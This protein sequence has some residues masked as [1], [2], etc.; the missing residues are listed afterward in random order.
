MT[1]RSLQDEGIALQKRLDLELIIERW[2]EAKPIPIKML[3]TRS[4]YP[5][6]RTEVEER[7]REKAFPFCVDTLMPASDLAKIA[8]THEKLC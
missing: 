2:V 7:N 3:R 6:K 1:L 5:S 8:C 4:R